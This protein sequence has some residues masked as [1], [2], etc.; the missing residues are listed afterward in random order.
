MVVAHRMHADG[1]PVTEEELAAATKSHQSTKKES[2]KPTKNPIAALIDN[3]KRTAQQD[4]ITGAKRKTLE[5]WAEGEPSSVAKK[6][7]SEAN[8][9]R[10]ASAKS[11]PQPSA[12]SAAGS[13]KKAG[14]ASSAATVHSERSAAERRHSSPA[15][16][17][18]ELPEVTGPSGLRHY[19]AGWPSKEVPAIE[20]LHKM[21]RSMP[22]KTTLD[23]AAM[24]KDHLHLGRT[25]TRIVRKQLSAMSYVEQTVVD[26]IRRIL[27]LEPLDGNSA[28]AAVE[29]IKDWLKEHPARPKPPGGFEY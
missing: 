11:T 24:A 3:Y 4:S 26:E 10:A 16:T 8:P 15:S 12:A 1:R 28:L 22:G 23:V 20:T 27:P 2:K 13:S 29:D 21:Y 25:A 19:A 17:D 6:G 14:G 7:P 18:V 9:A 5:A